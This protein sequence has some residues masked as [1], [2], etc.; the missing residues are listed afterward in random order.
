MSAST[1]HDR[2]LQ[3]A[4]ITLREISGN[5][6]EDDLELR[7]EQICDLIKKLEISIDRTKDHMLDEEKTLEEISGWSSSQGQELG[8]FRSLR[9]DLKKR[10]AAKER[11]ILQ[12]EMK[13]EIEKQKAINEEM[14]Q[15]RLREQKETRSRF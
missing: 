4:K 15:A 1:K 11:D 12:M 2:L 5:V 6:E 8:E 9:T 7:H 3:L 14:T 13:K 10:L